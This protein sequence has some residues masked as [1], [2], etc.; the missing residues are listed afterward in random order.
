MTR[1]IWSA[2]TRRGRG[3]SKPWAARAIRRASSRERSAPAGMRTSAPAAGQPA[4]GGQEALHLRGGD[5]V[6][7]GGPVSV[8]SE[9][10]LLPPALAGPAQGG[11]QVEDRHPRRGAD[12]AQPLGDPAAVPAG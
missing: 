6:A 9:V 12:V 11:A 3:R 7:E 10:G 5:A 2:R 1:R 4:S 8:V